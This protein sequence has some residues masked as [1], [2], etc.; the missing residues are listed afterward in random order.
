M[1]R[2]AAFIDPA[3][4]NL[5]LT[6]SLDEVVNRAMPVAEVREDLDRQP[7]DAKPDIGAD[8]LISSAND[9]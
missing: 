2:S 8:E 6:Q 4:G 3:H 5:H 9:L 1:D 7:R